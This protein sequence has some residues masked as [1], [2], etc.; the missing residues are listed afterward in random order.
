MRASVLTTALVLAGIRAASAADFPTFDGQQID[1][2]VGNVCYA[3]TTA[4]VDGDK[5]LDV[6]AV[7]EDSVFWFVNPT[8]EKRLILKGGTER[9]NVCI[10]AH[11]IDRDG[12]V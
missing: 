8:W 10:Q 9:D 4:D 7:T 5:R 12:R 6:V 3:V 11:D 2:H 1:P